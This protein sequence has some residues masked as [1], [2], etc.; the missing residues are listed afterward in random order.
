MLSQLD[1][2]RQVILLVAQYDSCMALEKLARKTKFPES[3]ISAQL[4]HLHKEEHGGFEVEKRSVRREGGGR[5]HGGVCRLEWRRR[6]CWW[7]AGRNGRNG[8][9]VTIRGAWLRAVG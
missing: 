4:R 3:S 7:R 5:R 9:G 2:V 1:V 6:G 8:R